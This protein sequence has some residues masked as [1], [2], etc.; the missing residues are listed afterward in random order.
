MARAHVEREIHQRVKL[1]LRQ[2]HRDELVHAM[3]GGLNVFDQQRFSSLLRNGLPRP[4]ARRVSIANGPNAA[5]V[6]IR[7]QHVALKQLRQR[8]PVFAVGKVVDAHALLSAGTA[9]TAHPGRISGG[10]RTVLW[11]WRGDQTQAAKTLPLVVWSPSPASSPATEMSSSSASQCRPRL[12]IRTCAHCSA[13]PCSKRGNH[14]SGT[15]MIRPSLRSTHMLA[16][17]K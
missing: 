8:Q 3:D 10:E 12:L 17:S 11:E 4:H 5:L 13:V 9:M 7:R 15:P 16:S 2:L 1:R 6:L 14:A